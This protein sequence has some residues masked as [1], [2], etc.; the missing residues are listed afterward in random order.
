MCRHDGGRGDDLVVEPFRPVRRHVLFGIDLGRAL[1]EGVHIGNR[2]LD[3]LR[4]EFVLDARFIRQPGL[5][6]PARRLLRRLAEDLLLLGR[7]LFERVG[8]NGEEGREPE[9]RATASCPP[10][11]ATA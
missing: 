3:S 6:L 2:D 10:L 8:G 5:I 7:E 4:D 9:S 1:A 11:P